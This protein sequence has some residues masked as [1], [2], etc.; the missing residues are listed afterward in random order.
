MPGNGFSFSIR[1]GCENNGIG[2]F[3]GSDDVVEVLFAAGA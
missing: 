3:N 2:V 1:V